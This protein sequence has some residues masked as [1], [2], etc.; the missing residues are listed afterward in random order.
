M[1][2]P[3]SGIRVTD[4]TMAYAGPMGTRVWSDLGAEVI[5]VEEPGTGDRARR[6][7]PF[8]GD[9]PEPERSGLFLALNANKRGIAVDVSNT[10]GVEIIRRLVGWA[11]I[12]IENKE[13]GYLN[14]LGLHYESV[15]SINPRLIMTS[16]TPFGQTG[17]YRD[18][19]GNDLT[20]SHMCGIA[21]TTPDRVADPVEQPPLKLGGRQ[22]DFV[23]GGTAAVATMFAVMAREFSG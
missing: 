16:I 5:K 19:K 6:T 10:A 15:K 7:G 13:V 9:L 12:L 18:F 14:K 3:L 17:P 2:A 4:L 21:W 20:I 1:T 8:Y 22:S 11:D 23:A